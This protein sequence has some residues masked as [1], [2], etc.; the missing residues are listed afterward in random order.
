V[1]EPGAD[2]DRSSGRSVHQLKRHDLLAWEIE[3]GQTRTAAQIDAADLRVPECGVKVERRAQVGNPVRRV[4]SPHGQFA[5]ENHA[6]PAASGQ[7]IDAV[8]PGILGHPERSGD[9]WVISLGYFQ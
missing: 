8:V 6:A 9:H 2:V 4:E 7:R 3:H 1:T 5:W